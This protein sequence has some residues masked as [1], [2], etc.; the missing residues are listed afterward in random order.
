M[1][2]NTTDCISFKL[3]W[4]FYFY[5]IEMWCIEMVKLY[6]KSVESIYMRAGGPNHSMHTIKHPV[7]EVDCLVKEIWGHW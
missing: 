6:I 1:P 7:K 2:W 5:I 4:I 3:K